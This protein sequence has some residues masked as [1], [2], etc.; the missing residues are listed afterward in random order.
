M[1][2]V[3]FGFLIGA[4]AA[5]WIYSKLMNSTGGNTKSAL[6]VAGSAGVAAWVVSAMIFAAIA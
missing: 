1:S 4:S 3:L 6:I 5:A 2:S